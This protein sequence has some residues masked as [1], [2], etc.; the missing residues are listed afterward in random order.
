[1]KKLTALPAWWGLTMM[2]LAGVFAFPAI[3][4]LQEGHEVEIWDAKVEVKGIMYAGGILIW[5]YGS[6]IL[7]AVFIAVGLQILV[8]SDRKAQ[9]E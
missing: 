2:V 1:M 8:T 4:Q 5:S 7:S 3:G 6:I 9:Q